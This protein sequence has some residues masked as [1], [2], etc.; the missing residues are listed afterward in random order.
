[1]SKRGVS[2]VFKILKFLL[3]RPVRFFVMAS[4]LLGLVGGLVLGASGWALLLAP[5]PH[6]NARQINIAPRP[7]IEQRNPRPRRIGQF[8]QRVGFF[9]L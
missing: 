7:V 6:Q 9:G 2:R 1:L 4:V 3:E 5:G 8:A